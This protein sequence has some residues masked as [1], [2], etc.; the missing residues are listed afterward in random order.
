MESA[1]PETMFGL[2]IE[3]LLRGIARRAGEGVFLFICRGYPGTGPFTIRLC[4]RLARTARR[5]ASLARRLQTEP[6]RPFAPRYAKRRPRQSP[7]RQIPPTPDAPALPRNRAWLGIRLLEARICAAQLDTLLRRPE[8][9]TLIAADYR[10]GRILRPLCHTIGL[11]NPAIPNY[12]DSPQPQ[13]ETQPE[14]QPQPTPIAIPAFAQAPASA[15]GPA[16]AAS[17]TP[18][19]PPPHLA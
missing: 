2:I 4:N 5:F 18:W 15:S 14:T 3:T 19:P 9:Q 1:A 6:A 11:R 13:P 10:F 7:G 12:P 17:L 16:P 8:T